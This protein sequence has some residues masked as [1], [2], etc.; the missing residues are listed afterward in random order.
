MTPTLHCTQ[1]ISARESSQPSLNFFSPMSQAMCFIVWNTKVVT[2][3]NFRRNFRDLLNS[4]NP[5]FVVLLKTKLCDHLGLIYEFGFDDYW[6]VPA[7]DRSGEIVLLW[8]T[9]F[10]GVTRKRQTF[11]KLHAMIKVLLNTQPWYFSTIYA[12]TDCYK[13]KIRWQN[14]KYLTHSVTDLWL[15]I[16]G[17]F[18]NVLTQNDKWGGRSINTSRCSNFW[19]CIKFFST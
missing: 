12:S 3:E 6:K 14:L 19:D 18:N 9:N 15:M 4:H 5:C 17:D 1:L 2:N 13:R 7:M 11:Q 10:F 8:R 16:S